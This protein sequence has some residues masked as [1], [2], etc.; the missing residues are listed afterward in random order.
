MPDVVAYRR[1]T[2]AARLVGHDVEL[3]AEV[4]SPA[5]RRQLD[6]EAAVVS[7]ATDYGIKWV[8]IV[9]P[10]TRLARWWH[11]GAETVTEP[12]WAAHIGTDASWPR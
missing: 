4:V 5:N 7:R 9:D 2:D 10:D 12:H 1:P 6:Y 3:V 8:L 11:D